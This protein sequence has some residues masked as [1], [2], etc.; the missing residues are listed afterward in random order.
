MLKAL[1][2]KINS[3]EN[4]MKTKTINLYEFKEL[5][6]Q[7]KEKAIKNY[8]E[9]EQYELLEDDLKESIELRLKD[10][11]I[12]FD[13]LKVYFSLS[14]SQGDGLCFEGRFYFK[15]YTFILHHSGRYYYSTSVNM[16]GENSNGNSLSEDSKI[17]KE[18]KKHYLNICAKAEKQGY[19]I[20]EYRMSEKEFNDFSES[21]DY[22][23][24]I[25]GKLENL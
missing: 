20:I 4:K 10:A 22:Y 16:I 15:K 2:S 25:D 24:T 12:D 23:Y 9:A 17:F 3:K 19:A 1:T 8:Y 6:K 14:H 13:D 5:T 21:N 7:A 18:F 11:H